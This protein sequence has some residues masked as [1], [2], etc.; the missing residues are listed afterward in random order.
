MGFGQKIT[1]TIERIP[2][3]LLI[4]VLL[5]A[6]LSNA[7]TTIAQSKPPEPTAEQLQGEIDKEIERWTRI[8]RRSGDREDRVLRMIDPGLSQDTWV[9]CRNRGEDGLRVDDHVVIAGQE[10]LVDQ[11]EVELVE[12]S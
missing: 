11:A 6:G 5:A 7:F 9:E 3:A 2:R 12:G 8:L 4:L 1:D 10:Q